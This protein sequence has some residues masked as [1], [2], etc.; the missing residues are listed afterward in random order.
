MNADAGKRRGSCR[1]SRLQT[2][3][4]LLVAGL[5]GAGSASAFDPVYP[6]VDPLRSQPEVLAT[7]VTLPGD[8][9]PVP[10]PAYKD[11]AT[12]LAL[13]E[14]VDLAL[15]HNPQIK[16]S[17]ANIKI[18]AGAV[19]EAR[20]AYLPAVT[21]S[22]G[23][24]NDRIRS[25]N[26]FIAPSNIDQ[27]TAQGTL[28]WRLLDFGGR[29]ANHRAAENLLTAALASHNATLQKAL[30]GVIQAYCDT[31]TTRAAFK[32][33]TESVEIATQTLHSAKV[34]EGKGT[35]SQTDTLQATTALAKASLEKNRAQGDYDKAL[36][37]LG[38]L[39]GVPGNPAITLPEDQDMKVEEHGG[40]ALAAWL[41]ETEKHHP[42][43]VAARSQ[44]E[45]AQQRVEAT[46][47]AG[48]PFL[49]LSASY[50]QNTRPGEA[51]TSTAS[52][53]TTVSLMVTVP[54]FDG[55]SSTY[56]LQGARAQV[57]QKEAVLADTERQIAMEV[58]KAHADATSAL[59]NLEASAALLAAA[60][61]A[62]A[63][64]QRKYA[65]GAAD[66]NELLNTQ[67]AL[68]DARHE[69]IRCL[70]EWRSARLRL[71]ASAGQMGR[72][73]IEE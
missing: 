57:E 43:L 53:E 16:S 10:C 37:V 6:F 60:Q 64:S 3:A 47:S 13:S 1:R 42:A 55:F 15:C 7:G 18:Q 22:L 65:K 73:V 70:A 50:Y 63:V 5:L 52:K 58:V 30:A 38:Y 29:S 31:L 46:R 27:N 19:G 72:T 4:I 24:T 56:K 2:A 44:L 35:L 71:F 48:L 54:L 61:N 17:W 23:R 62:L 20:A 67:A 12:P 68:A 9:T 25:S 33:K 32:A 36:S 51:V 14:A 40:K 8:S 45:A 49:G 11:F 28:T 21:G 39:L 69:R 66:I 41:E 59:Q 34:R 26:A